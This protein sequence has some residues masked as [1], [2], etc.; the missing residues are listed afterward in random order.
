MQVKHYRV[1]N[2]C[3]FDIGATLANQ[4]QIVI[5]AGAFQLM[6]ADDIVYIESICSRTKYFAKRW[7]VPMDQDGKEV[8]AEELGTYIQTDEHPHLSDEEAKAL[9]SKS[10]KE[11]KAYLEEEDDPNE[12]HS[13]ATVAKD[14]NLTADKLKVLKK[15]VPN[16]DLFVEDEEEKEE[17]EKS[18]KKPAAR[19]RTKK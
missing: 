4:Q 5:K 15:K 19:T 18:V 2:K 17:E 6:T 14:M 1:Y 7:L 8:S 9:L 3:K 13:I 11:V 10:A 12:L 16:M